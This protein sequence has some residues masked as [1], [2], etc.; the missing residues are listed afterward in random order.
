MSSARLPDLYDHSKAATLPPQP[1]NGTSNATTSSGPISRLPDY[2]VGRPAGANGNGRCRPHR[3]G[4]HRP[5][6]HSA[7]GHQHGGDDAAGTD[8][9]QTLSGPACCVEEW[10]VS[11]LK[12]HPRQKDFFPDESEA[13]D[14]ELVADM[15]ANGQQDDIDIL[16]DGTILGGHR[17]VKAARRLRWKT[18]KVVVHHELADDEAAAEAFLINDN[19]TRR[20]LT[21]FQKVRC[22]KRRVEL[23]KLGKVV[24]PA[25]CN[26]L[27][28]TRDKI[29]KLVDKSGREVERYLRVLKTSVEVQDACDAGYLTLEEAGKVAG[30]SGETQQQIAKQLREQGLENAKVIY[31]DY[32]PSKASTRLGAGTI[33]CNL[34]RALEVALDELPGNINNLGWMDRDDLELVEQAKDLFDEIKGHIAKYLEDEDE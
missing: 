12:E 25:E 21:E 5:D 16:P 18:I 19:Y 2:E 15:E 1:A 27:K 29:G 17:R 3:T 20:Q 11:K 23:A 33:W 24:L 22:A 10:D 8:D 32:R 34:R 6:A 9:G 4:E 13:A 30:F 31:D 28:K 7:N 26:G 14:A